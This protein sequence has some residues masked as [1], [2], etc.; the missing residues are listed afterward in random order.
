MTKSMLLLYRNLGTNEKRHILLKENN[1][2]PE[3]CCFL[4]IDGVGFGID[5]P[6]QMASN[7]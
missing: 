4:P 3:S 7:F 2:S 1:L 6:P 5:S